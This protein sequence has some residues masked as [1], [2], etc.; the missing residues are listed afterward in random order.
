MGTKLS[1]IDR[2]R[3]ANNAPQKNLNQPTVVKDDVEE[4]EE[5]FGLKEGS[6]PND[7]SLSQEPR[8][9]GELVVASKKKVGRPKTRDDQKYVQVHLVMPETT[10]S[11]IQKA[12]LCHRTN[13]NGYIMEL[14]QEDLLKNGAGYNSIYETMAKYAK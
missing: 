3:A 1:T 6:E 7:V 8:N 11:E 9:E 10:K 4:I 14:I 13:M 5:F 12:C 2:L